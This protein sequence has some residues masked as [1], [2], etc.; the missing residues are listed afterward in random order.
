MALGL[1]SRYVSGMDSMAMILDDTQG[2]LNDA[3][4]R[5]VGLNMGSAFPELGE[6]RAHAVAIAIENIAQHERVLRRYGR[7][8]DA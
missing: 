5:L 3:R 8:P 7:S 6:T 1:Q 2:Y 4:I